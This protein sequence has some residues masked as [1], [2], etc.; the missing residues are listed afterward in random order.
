[1]L[2]AVDQ[3]GSPYA[4]ATLETPPLAFAPY[5]APRYL[6]S[7]SRSHREWSARSFLSK[8]INKCSRCS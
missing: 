2:A 1:M 3:A 4:P 5:H 8:L 7:W 6:A